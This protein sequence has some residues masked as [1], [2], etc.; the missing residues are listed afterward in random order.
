MERVGGI[1]DL[2]A[3][4]LKARYKVVCVYAGVD[5]ICDTSYCYCSFKLDGPSIE[6]LKSCSL[7][8][9]QRKDRN[10]SF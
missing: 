8:L 2:E 6:Q 10:R 1:Y 7:F 9:A 4:E 5:Q 3:K